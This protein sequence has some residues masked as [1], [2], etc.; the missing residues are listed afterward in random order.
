MN[1]PYKHYQSYINELKSVLKKHSS[2]DITNISICCIH[3]V[4]NQAGSLSIKFKHSDYTH[5]VNFIL[6]KDGRTLFKPSTVCINKAEDGVI[7]WAQ[8]DIDKEFLRNDLEHWAEYVRNRYY[9][10]ERIKDFWKESKEELVTTTWHPERV[11][12]WLE[13]GVCVEDM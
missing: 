6:I 7:T 12:N 4:D 1:N 3:F 2:V 10:A 5:I 8:S 13:A 9:A 11:A